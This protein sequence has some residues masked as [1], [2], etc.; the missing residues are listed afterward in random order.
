MI[1]RP[2]I[3]VLTIA[4]LV[5]AAFGHAAPVVVVQ[6]GRTNWHIRAEANSQPIEFA[7]G[8]LQRY[9]RT[10]TATEVPIA[11]AAG[12]PEIVLGLR[13][14]LAADDAAALPAPAVGYDGYAVAIRAA[15]E[16]RPARILI[17]GDNDR[18]VIYGVY[19]L[20]E[21]FGCRWFYPAQDPADPEVVPKQATLTINP[22][23]WAVASPMKY[24]ICNGD[25]WF[26]EMDL[27][28]A[29]KQLDWA[30]KNRYNTMGWQSE[31]KT[32]LIAQYQR[33]EKAGLMD[34]L[35]RRGMLL[36]GP[37]HSFDHF[38]RAEDHMAAHPEWFGM[39]NGK[40]V[41]QSFIGAQFCWSNPAARKQFVENVEAFVKAAPRI[42][43]LC[44]VPF[45]GGV[46]CACPECSRIGASNLLMQ[47]MGE[48]IERLRQSAPDVLV[49]TVGGYGAMSDPPTDVKI[50]PRQR[51]VWA[52]W[53]RY[54]GIGYDDER[55]D[56]KANLEAWHKASPGGITI[57]QYY[58]DNFAE[59]WVLPPFALALQGDRRYLLQ[60]KIESVYVLFWPPGYWWNHGLNGH[61][62][63][64]CFYDAALDPF[65]VIRD[66]AMHYFGPQAGPL[67]AD[68]YTQWAREID[69][70]YRVKDD[71]R[72][73]DR[74][75]LAAQRTK[76]ID[77]AVAATQGN[78]V[79]SRR[80]GKVEKLHALA[81]RLAELH[82]RQQEVRALRKAGKLEAARAAL[83][84]YR[85][86]T[87]DLLTDMGELADL[88][89]GLID[90]NEV[91]G[92]IKMAL[93][94]WLD[95][96]AKAIE[97]AEKAGATTSK[98]SSAP[99]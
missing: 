35:A 39:R 3:H 75:M 72:D 50:H 4:A 19:D 36:H 31:S 11:P 30:M 59:P 56:R 42:S 86:F 12:D 81:E 80:V 32:T 40:R 6:N 17:A 64:H 60:Q 89:Q 34:A 90:R 71:P 65:D 85:Q 25:A 49:E 8:E 95:E 98:P 18:G 57:C 7:A 22:S 99:R 66:Y 94:G 91:N 76:W 47:L 63:G 84:D 13:Q 92:F 88:E 97:A 74:A 44:I 82:K 70:A 67:L 62:S 61:I 93:N 79:L 20:L 26:F 69:L 24:R 52:H 54:Y 14:R 37:A 21:R 33:L 58:T 96:Q 51:V 78:P 2:T 23:A 27:S 68:Y 28:A 55:Y 83:A 9:V 77:P 53:G 46:A 16:G 10:M 38:L 5:P 73:S 15:Q 29:A 45:D 1:A 48:V 43:I 41:P 87:A